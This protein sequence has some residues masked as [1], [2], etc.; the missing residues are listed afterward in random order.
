MISTKYSETFTPTRGM[1]GK[2]TITHIHQRKNV[3]YFGGIGA[4]VGAAAGAV[5]LGTLA[6][7]TGVEGW[8]GVFLMLGAMFGFV[9][10]GI[11][12]AILGLAY[13]W[14]VLSRKARG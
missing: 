11:V 1:N 12:G 4:A 2:G 13:G 14:F 7:V 9:G 3:W 6:Y 8:E 5:A 10:G